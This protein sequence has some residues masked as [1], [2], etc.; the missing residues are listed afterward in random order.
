MDGLFVHG[1]KDPVVAPVLY[2][3][4]TRWWPPTCLVT[5]WVAGAVLAGAIAT[6][7]HFR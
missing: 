6:G 7:L 3:A 4:N 5:D 1:V 2:V